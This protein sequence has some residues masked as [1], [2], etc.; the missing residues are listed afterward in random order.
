[1]I[2]YRYKPGALLFLLRA[3]GAIFLL[4][5]DYSNRYLDVIKVLDCLIQLYI[6]YSKYNLGY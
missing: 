2:A 6:L 1:M 3:L 4:L 5:D